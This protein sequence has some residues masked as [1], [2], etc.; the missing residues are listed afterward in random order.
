[1]PFQKG[2]KFSPGRKKG[3]KHKRT[4]KAEVAQEQLRQAIFQNLQ[5]I[6]AAAIR[7]ALGEQFIYRVEKKEE[8]NETHVQLTDPDEIREGL[9]AIASGNFDENYYYIST[10]PS[11]THAIKEL[12]DRGFGKAKENVEHNIGEKTL[13][14]L[15][16]RALVRGREKDDTLLNSGVIHSSYAI[17]EPQKKLNDGN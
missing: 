9:D 5:P 4:I 11:N 17:V 14:F 6:T 8:G 1:M 2:H 3:S 15:L 12:F 10:K 7:S 13:A 16:E